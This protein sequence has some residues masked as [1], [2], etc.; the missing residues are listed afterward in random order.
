MAGACLGRRRRRR[1]STTRIV[2]NSTAPRPAI[3]SWDNSAPVKGRLTF[4]STEG[5]VVG[6]VDGVGVGVVDGVVVGVVPCVVGC[7][8]GCVVAVEVVLVPPAAGGSVL[9]AAVSVTG[10]VVTGVRVVLVVQAGA[11]ALPGVPQLGPVQVAVF[12]MVPVAPVALAV[13]AKARV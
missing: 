13:T 7:S 10:R 11:G 3:H 4:G 6:I 8:A 1:A 5:E 12:V 9:G 2:P